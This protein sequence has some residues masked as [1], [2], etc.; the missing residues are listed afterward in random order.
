M[1][2]CSTHL[3]LFQLTIIWRWDR[4]QG[5]TA[6]ISAGAAAISRVYAAF[7]NSTKVSAEW[8][9][10][11]KKQINIFANL[12]EHFPM[13]NGYVYWLGSQLPKFPK[14]GTKPYDDLLKKTYIAYHKKIQVTSGH[15]TPSFV[16]AVDDPEQTIDQVFGAAVNIGEGTDSGKYNKTV[17]DCQERCQFALDHSYESAYLGAIMEGQ[18]HLVLTLIG[19]GAFNNNREL[20][21]NTIIE[22]H[23]KYTQHSKCT[24]EKVSIVVF[25][26]DEVTENF[27]HNLMDHKI[28]FIYEWYKGDGTAEIKQK[29]V[30]S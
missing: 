23:L 16:E 9:Q 15:R 30:G 18:K 13:K 12:F 14:R 3:V 29:F 19:G 5:P 28:P 25:R 27:L 17:P 10:T 4:T 26:S 20:I 1:L 24:L 2:S 6:A 11:R 8:P 7:F 22:M 21:Y